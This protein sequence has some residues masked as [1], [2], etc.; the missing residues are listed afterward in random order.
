MTTAAVARATMMSL[1]ASSVVCFSTPPPRP[2][3]LQSPLQPRRGGPSTTLPRRKHDGTERNNSG[4]G[5]AL[6]L[7]QSAN[8]NNSGFHYDN[9]PRGTSFL[10]QVSK[11]DLWERRQMKRPLRRKEM[12]D[13]RRVAPNS[14][15]DYVGYDDGNFIENAAGRGHGGSM[16]GNDNN[17]A[18]IGNNE[19]GNNSGLEAFKDDVSIN[20]KS[21]TDLLREVQISQNAQTRDVRELNSRVEN[22]AERIYS[23]EEGVI[24][25]NIHTPRGGGNNGNASQG[26]RGGAKDSYSNTGGGGGGGRSSNK[27]ED[28]NFGTSL[29]G[30]FQRKIKDVINE[31]DTRG[32][33]GRQLREQQVVGDA[34][35]TSS[36]DSMGAA[37]SGNNMVGGE[38]AYHDKIARLESRIDGIDE[39]LKDTEYK[40]HTQMEYVDMLLVNRGLDGSIEDEQGE[41]PFRP[42]P[43]P[44]SFEDDESSFDFDGMEF[45]QGRPMMHMPP[46]P[47]FSFDHGGQQQ[48]MP[49]MPPPPPPPMPHLQQQQGMPPP[50]EGGPQTMDSNNN[51]AT[52]PPPYTGNNM[53]DGRTYHQERNYIDFNVPRTN[54]FLSNQNRQQQTSTTK[55]VNTRSN[56]HHYDQANG[57]FMSAFSK[58][59]NERRREFQPFRDPRRN[60]VS[61]RDQL[62]RGVTNS[63][64]R[65]GFSS[66]PPPPP[67]MMMDGGLMMGDGGEGGGPML[68]MVQGYY[69]EEPFHQFYEETD[70]GGSGPMMGNMMMGSDE[71]HR[72]FY[73]DMMY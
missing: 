22:I 41:P 4:G 9:E 54:E 17:N 64:N 26:I 8:D 30:E 1:L 16:S 48:G 67:S 6:F 32:G 42:H 11:R 21:M 40:F 33:G 39:G 27:W 55:S 12:R 52:P 31:F 36:S 53:D 10:S 58:A 28:R 24:G 71:E 34:A 50:R 70:G 62:P 72:P 63:P 65:R 45:Q 25:N 7:S 14:R 44:P 49:R 2:S 18:A 3:M 23:S 19:G 47:Q 13:R 46:P 29:D 61:A 38:E 66:V 73:D 56:T 69:E 37:M 20:L 5:F 43:P 51:N 15:G 57:S 60:E 59:D 35:T 68:G